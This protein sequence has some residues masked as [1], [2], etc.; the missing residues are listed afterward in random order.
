[1]EIES[2]GYFAYVLVQ[3]FENSTAF[4]AKAMPVVF[5]IS[6]QSQVTED[7]YLLLAHYLCKI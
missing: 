2:W 7:Y 6:E 1:M 5:E 3:M 4:S